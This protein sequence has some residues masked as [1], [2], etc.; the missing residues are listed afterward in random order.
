M[1]WTLVSH[2]N[3]NGFNWISM[4]TSSAVGIGMLTH[5][6]SFE[7]GITKQVLDVR[8]VEELECVLL[9]KL[10]IL[11]GVESSLNLLGYFCH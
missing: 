3:H 4:L 11:L 9:T 5:S 2:S 6:T 7:M 8:Q 10:V 1:Y